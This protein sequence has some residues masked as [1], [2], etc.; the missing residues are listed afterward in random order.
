MNNADLG[1][2]GNLLVWRAEFSIFPVCLLEPFPPGAATQAFAACRS[3]GVHLRETSQFGSESA[4]T[5]N[6]WPK[7]SANQVFH[8]FIGR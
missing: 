3:G 5:R 8:T 2:T 4:V 1:L 6:Q 7:T